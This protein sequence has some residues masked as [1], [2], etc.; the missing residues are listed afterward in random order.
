MSKRI[1]TL[2]HP[3]NKEPSDIFSGFNW[4]CLFFGSFWFAVK[5]MWFWTF[6]SGLLALLTLGA[7]WIIFP[8]LANGMYRKH[9]RSQGWLTEEQTEGAPV[10]KLEFVQPSAQQM[11]TFTHPLAGVDVQPQVTPQPDQPQPAQSGTST[12]PTA[13][14]NV[15]PPPQ[16]TAVGSFRSKSFIFAKLG[17]GISWKNAY[18]V[19]DADAG[20]IFLELR[21]GE[22][23]ALGKLARMG[24]FATSSG[25][26]VM[27]KTQDGQPFFRVKGGGMKGGADVFSGANTQIG[28]IKR[29]NILSMNFEGIDAQGIKKFKT[30]SQ[31]FGVLTSS[32]QILKAETV[33][34]MIKDINKDNAKQILGASFDRLNNTHKYDYAYHVSLSEEME[35]LDKALLLGSVYCI[36]H[37]SGRI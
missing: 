11:T 6:G 10:P 26:D 30:K 3:I 37:I 34:G 5:G 33:I 21:E 27:F 2:Y 8:F 29:A 35:D 36:A 9:L 13:A 28:S 23:G 25:F 7:S 19:L 17:Q 16:P 15:A 31:G 4:P 22:I 20:A 18:D 12:M 1:G 14:F 32:H 24:T